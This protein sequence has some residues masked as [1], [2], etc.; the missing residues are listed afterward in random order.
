MN[1]TTPCH[2][3]VGA[4]SWHGATK[5]PTSIIH[6]TW[7]SMV[8]SWGLHHLTHGILQQVLIGVDAHAKQYLHALLTTFT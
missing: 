2:R 3:T 8:T 4:H 7:S 6:E 5:A 1:A